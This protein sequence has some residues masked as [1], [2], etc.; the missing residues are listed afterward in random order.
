MP[1]VNVKVVAELLIE[2]LKGQRNAVSDQMAVLAALY[3]SQTKELKAAKERIAEL[4]K[5]LTL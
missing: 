1:T 5:Q 2:E 4:E 3:T